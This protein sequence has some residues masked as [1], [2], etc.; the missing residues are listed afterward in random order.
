MRVQFTRLFHKHK[1][2][3]YILGL[4]I[5]KN[6]IYFADNKLFGNETLLLIQTLFFLSCYCIFFSLDRKEPKGQGLA[7]FFV[8][9]QESKNKIK[10]KFDADYKS[11]PAKSHTR[12]SIVNKFYAFNTVL[13]QKMWGFCCNFAIYFLIWQI[14]YKH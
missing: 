12:F 10:N 9:R 13:I 4:I 14:F 8:P 3:V 7:Y 6:R 11:A 2:L 5:Y 1:I